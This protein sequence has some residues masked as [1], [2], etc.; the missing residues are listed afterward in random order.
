[1]DA[2][3]KQNSIHE[4]NA[5]ASKKHFLATFL[6]WLIKFSQ[7]F[8]CPL[9]G[10]TYANFLNLKQTRHCK[11]FI[12]TELIFWPPA[13]NSSKKLEFCEISWVVF[14]TE[15][16]PDYDLFY[17][18]DIVLLSFMRQ[19]NV[20]LF[21]SVWFLALRRHVTN[22]SVMLNCRYVTL[23][24]QFLLQFMVGV[25]IKRAYGIYWI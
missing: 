3:P 15:K 16:Q 14:F 5:E 9:W 22:N 6:R 1:M 20:H 21:K 11:K 19:I 8:S 2:L 25:K 23:T 4:L 18:Y 24:H 13:Y 7:V 10:L 17:F 12:F